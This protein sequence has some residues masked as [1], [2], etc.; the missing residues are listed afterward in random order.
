MLL[1]DLRYRD[2]FSEGD[3]QHIDR[4]LV[5]DKLAAEQ[6]RASH[7]AETAESLQEANPAGDLL[8][9]L[10]HLRWHSGSN[11]EG[12]SVPCPGR[13]P[14]VA[15]ALRLARCAQGGLLY[16]RKHVPFR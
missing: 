11:S 10:Q 13:H 6:P 9:H 3:R 5:T 12:A 7:A 2:C 15:H 16:L 4:Q 14:H 8:D 1:E